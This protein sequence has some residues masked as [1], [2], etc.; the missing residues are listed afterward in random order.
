MTLTFFLS[1]V[2]GWYLLII[3][4]L[5]LFKRNEFV[6][7]VKEMVHSKAMLLLAG[8]FGTTCGLL[9]VLSHNIWDGDMMSTLVTV[10]GW[11]VF[12]KGLSIVFLPQQ[13]VSM[14][15]R[16]SNLEK[17][18]YLYAAVTIILGLYLLVGF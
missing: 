13:V 3:G 2:F 10:L 9:V 5:F 17:L 12:L 18:S 1:Q 7:A 15:T 14:W 16:W 8:L 6:H 4:A 11:V